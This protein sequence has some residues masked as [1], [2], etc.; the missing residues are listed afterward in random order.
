M[1]LD[2]QLKNPLIFFDLETTGLDF[3]YD[4]AIEL[5]AVKILPDGTNVKLLK[6]FNPGMKIPS[7]IEKLTGIRNEDV[8]SE[9]TFAAA[10]AEIEAFFRGCDLAGYNIL[11]FDCKVMVEEFKR[12]GLDFKLEDRLAVDVQT[13]FHQKEKRDLS[14]AYK[15]YCSKDLV[16]AHSATADSDATFEIFLSQLK[17]YPDLPRDIN[18]LHQFC[19]GD[20]DRFVDGEG[21]FF[22]RDAQAVFNFGRYKSHSLKD[23]VKNDPSYLQWVLSPDRQFSQE[24]VDICYRALKGEF[25]VKKKPAE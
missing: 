25:P 1:T 16:G 13:I 23:V 2:L 8:A 15:F 24:V 17:R 12:A 21:K 14:A 6:R 20:Q 7:E 3:K 22:W 10:A 19:R 18:G 5:G 11:R 4:R 9:P